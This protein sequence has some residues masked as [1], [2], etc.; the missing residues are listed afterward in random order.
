MHLLLVDDEPLARDELSYLLLQYDPSFSIDQADSIEMAQ[1][2]LLEKAYD[3][4]FLD[5]HLHD[6]SGM[7][8][9][10]TINKMPHPPKI[11]FATAYDHYAVQAFD[12]NAQDYLLK[13]YE[14]E[15]LAQA[16]KKSLKEER[17]EEVRR[18]AAYP[19]AHPL[20][21]EDRIFMI[22]TEKIQLLEAQQGATL[23]YTDDQTYSDNGSLVYWET[24]LDPQIFMR[25]HRSYLVNLKAIQVIEP[26]F[27]QTLQ[28]TLANGQKAQVSRTFVKAFREVM[29]LG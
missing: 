23:L 26:W 17:T 15:R 18:P 16:L 9:A 27:N 3:L 28:V 25:I 20:A 21:V 11:I 19:Q 13:P 12:Q 4:V 8:L 10:T 1:S 22:P 7:T 14:P 6:Q 29:G 5:I 2:F 24:R